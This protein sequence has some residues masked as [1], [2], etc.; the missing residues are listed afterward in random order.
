MP[1]LQLV[2][3]EADED[4]S[5]DRLVDALK[6]HGFKA[7]AIDSEFRDEESGLGVEIVRFET[8]ARS[9]IAEAKRFGLLVTEFYDSPFVI[10]SDRHPSTVFD[11]RSLE[12][13]A[14]R[15]DRALDSAIEFELTFAGL[16]ILI[17]TVP[18]VFRPG[19]QR[20]IVVSF[21]DKLD[22]FAAFLESRRPD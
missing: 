4:S 13:D 18:V 8:D 6:R 19:A 15:L 11:V 14:A 21:M 7:V 22:R 9:K 20:E 1:R 16:D 10:P 17:K 2:D 12:K 3:Q 5:I